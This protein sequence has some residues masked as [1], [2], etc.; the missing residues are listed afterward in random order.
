MS[1]GMVSTGSSDVTASTVT[2]TASVKNGRTRLKTFY[3]KTAGS[4]S[5]QVV[6]RDGS[7]GA[8]VLDMTFN[9]GDDVS[10]NLPGSGLLF[11]TECHATLT[12]VTSFTGFF[13]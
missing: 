2:T 11:K 4:G 7:T 13:A 6:L 12:A 5:P 9:T 10:L 3:L 1:N 8:V